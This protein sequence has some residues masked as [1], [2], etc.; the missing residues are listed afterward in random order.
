MLLLVNG[1]ALPLRT[2]LKGLQHVECIRIPY[3][4]SSISKIYSCS[5]YGDIHYIGNFMLAKMKFGVLKYT[6]YSCLA[7]DFLN[8]QSLKKLLI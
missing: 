5:P 2:N 4:E 6:T 8:Y 7:Q 3:S 1:D